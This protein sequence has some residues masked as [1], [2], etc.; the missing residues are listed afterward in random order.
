MVRPLPDQSK[1]RSH[2]PG[3]MRLAAAALLLGPLSALAANPP[4]EQVTR[5]FQ[6][7][8]TLGA[9]QAV[10]VEN[11]FG[12]V[13]LHGTSGRDLKISATIRVQ[14][15]S[16]T[17]SEDFAQKIRIEVDQGGQGVQVRTIYPEE[18]SSWHMG[19]R[20]ASYSV[21]Y[22]IAIPADAPLTVRNS[23]GSVETTGIHSKSEIENSHGAL[24]V[25]DAGP[26]RL[27]NSFGSIDVSETAGDLALTDNNGPV[28]VSQIK[29]SL[30]LTNRF[31]RITVRNVQGPVTIT[32]GN[33]A[34]NLADAASAHITTSFGDVDVRNIHGDLT[35]HDNNGNVDVSWVGGAADITDSFGNVTFSDV[36]GRVNCRTNNGRVK[37]RSLP[38][39][40]VSI[41]NAF[42]NIELEDVVGALDAETS[43]GKIYLREA[44]G[45]VTLRSS[46]GAIDAS[47]IPKGIRAVTGNGDINL[48]NIGADT[49]A[50][51]TFGMV[52]TERIAGNLTVENNNGPVTVHNVKGD[53]QVKTSFAG[54]TLESIGG[55]IT[56]D[57][58]NGAIS[59][60]ATRPPSGCRDISLKTSFAPIHVRIPDGVGYNVSARTSFGRISSD[61]PLSSSGSTGGDSLS[62][63]IGSGGCKLQL[64][65]SNASIEIAKAP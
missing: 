46:F 42:G 6:K 41:H 40:L 15:G 27:R 52:L 45:S 19:H 22:E 16:R 1:K 13:R 56:V 9:G 53:A 36:K 59:V 31:G 34:V 14:T 30:E 7:T 21:D 20:K 26:A 33:G 55:K 17:E 4:Q 8:V 63:T 58:Q 18:S 49:Y 10:Q 65:D 12:Q 35:L 2:R 50:K 39:D 64:T 5:D 11:K 48:T 38:G 23:F 43:N 61:I 47:N 28:Q 57:N 3:A 54:V 24:T 62:G 60:V 44:R 29:G 25:R 32:G 37:G 51:T